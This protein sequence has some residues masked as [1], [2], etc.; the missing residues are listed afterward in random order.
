M[1]QAIISGTQWRENVKENCAGHRRKGKAREARDEGAAKH[2][3]TEQA[4]RRK[5][6]HGRTLPVDKIL[7]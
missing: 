6:A 1:L 7:E 2:G 4:E 5:V 3:D